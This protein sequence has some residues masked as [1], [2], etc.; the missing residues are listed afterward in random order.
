MCNKIQFSSPEDARKYLTVVGSKARISHKGK[1]IR[2]M[3]SYQCNICGFWHLTS[4]SA[5]ERKKHRKATRDKKAMIAKANEFGVIIDITERWQWL[6]KNGCK[7]IKV[8][9]GER[10]YVVFKGIKFRYY[11]D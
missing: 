10:S 4:L 8:I 6:I 2:R 5:K 11:I 1:D 9:T 7:D 3:T